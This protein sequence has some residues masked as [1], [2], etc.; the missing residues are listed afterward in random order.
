VGN[1]EQ[2]QTLS[3]DPSAPGGL[4]NPL[5]FQRAGEGG[6]AA[7]GRAVLPAPDGA[8]QVPIALE[9][10]PWRLD[11]ALRLTAVVKATFSFAAAP[12]TPVS[13]AEPFRTHD[14]HR[15]N[16]PMAHVVAASDRAPQK[17]RVDVTL[18]GNACPPGGR[19]VPEM[20]ARL[21]L[22]QGGVAVIDK[23]VR[24][25]GDRD[26]ADAT[27]A[28]F[29]VMPVV[30]ER[31][32][33]GKSP[34][35]PIGVSGEDDE[36]PNIVDPTNAWRPAGFGPISAGWPLRAK[37]LGE[38]PR[39]NLD[40]FVIDLP[41]DFDWAYFQSAPPDQ[42]VD[43][44]SKVAVIVLQGFRPERPLIEAALPAPHAVGAVYGL[45]DAS[46][47]APVALD[48]QADTLHIDA[49]RWTCTLAFRA[50]VHVR[51]EAMLA[52]LLIAAGVGINGGDPSIPTTRPEATLAPRP[53]EGA[54]A[55]GAAEPFT[56]TLAPRSRGAAPGATLPFSADPPAADGATWMFS[57]AE[58]AAAVPLQV[59]AF[60][61]PVQASP[62]PVA[63]ALPFIAQPAAPASPPAPPASP[64][65]T[66]PITPEPRQEL[67]PEEEIDLDRC[68]ALTAA[69]DEPGATISDVLE[70][71]DLSPA[72]WTK[73]EQHWRR[74]MD[75]ELKHGK[76]VLRD[77]FDEMYARAIEAEHPDRFGVAEYARLLAAEKKG[78]L[79]AAITEQGLSVAIGM[80]LR[81]VWSRRVAADPALQK[82]L[83]QALV[84]LAAHR[85]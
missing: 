46:P 80:R 22:Q 38:V 18:L 55:G 34:T 73:A 37:R 62:P 77:H 53:L 51:D 28:P 8:A 19:P 5:P 24:V 82:Q 10:V 23:A 15:R 43:E 13:P 26:A 65:L 39:R 27:P 81:R 31:A 57:A 36:Q 84:E 52:R 3:I 75:R 54:A 58:G 17:P 29:T 45:D 74:A 1:R 71:H 47:D 50:H 61:L 14:V 16:Q 6:L 25:L 4:A 44:L 40:A 20:Q 67:A 49:E 59:A 9:T 48:F 78:L 56:G 69:L 64:P 76:P 63:A 68:A 11:G 72:V 35:N 30:Y 2:N 33:G 79:S 32:Y 60:S 7:V 70:A 66:G 21:A 85:G 42:Q 83:A 41:A 12:M